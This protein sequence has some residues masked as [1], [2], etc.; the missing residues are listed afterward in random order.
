MISKPHVMRR[1]VIAQP[2]SV[3]RLT[4]RFCG[5]NTSAEIVLEV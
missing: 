1:F 2:S 3:S 5:M 4:D